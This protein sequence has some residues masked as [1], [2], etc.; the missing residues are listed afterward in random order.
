LGPSSLA[1]QTTKS[2]DNFY[3]DYLKA[4]F[5]A[6][7]FIDI[8]SYSFEAFEKSN[9]RNLIQGSD[10]LTMYIQKPYYTKTQYRF[11][12]KRAYC[13]NG[14]ELLKISAPDRKPESIQLS[15]NQASHQATFSMFLNGFISRNS[16]MSP[17]LIEKFLIVSDSVIIDNKRYYKLTQKLDEELSFEYLIDYH[18]LLLLKEHTIRNGEYINQVDYDN[19]KIVDGAYIPF[20]RTSKNFSNLVIERTIVKF[21]INPSFPAGFFNCL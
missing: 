4:N 19:Y 17:N 18:S 16:L 14:I 5:P 1:A 11:P 2:Y 3:N 15:G 10:S 20:K 9:L 21:T 6:T 8:K 12:D 7:K 13:Y